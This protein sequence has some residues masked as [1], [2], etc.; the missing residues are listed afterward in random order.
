MWL[1]DNCAYANPFLEPASLDAL[2]VSDPDDDQVLTF[3]LAD[4]G[5]DAERTL[6]ASELHQAVNTFVDRLGATDRELI[7]RVFWDGETQSQVAHD[8][9]VSGAAIS[10]RM[11]RIQALGR[12]VLAEYQNSPFLQ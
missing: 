7:Q 9:K 3:P 10:K 11:A 8:F 2:L 12:K 5:A 1:M 6:Q 4:P